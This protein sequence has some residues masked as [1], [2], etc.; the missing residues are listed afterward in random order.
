[1]VGCSVLPPNHFSQRH[2]PSTAVTAG[3]IMSGPMR[4]A[5]LSL[6]NLI[7]LSYSGATAPA[8]A[9]RSNPFQ[10]S[11]TFLAEAQRENAFPMREF[12]RLERP[13]TTSMTL[14][15]GPFKQHG[16]TPW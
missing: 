3:G 11:S 15:N 4:H 14:W 9:A 16:R 7:L 12:V 8:P 2:G 5:D 13:G 1:M 6:Q 10:P